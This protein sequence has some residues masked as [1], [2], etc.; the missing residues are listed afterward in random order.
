MMEF[1]LNFLKGLAI[2]I[3]AIA[4]GVSGGALAVIFGVYEKLNE[5]VATIFHGFRRKVIYLLPF[6]LGGGL[7][8]LAFSNIMKYLFA[9]HDV[10]MKYL[11]IGFMLGTLP[12]LIKEANTRGFKKRYIL[13]VIITFSI[14]VIFSMLENNAVNMGPGATPTIVDLIIYGALIGFGT[15]VP[16][17][18]A[19]FILMYLGAYE[20]LLE[21]IAS[22]NLFMLIPAGLGFVLSNLIFA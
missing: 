7:G 21:A 12:S 4:P 20:I 15:I 11:F 1:V 5:A 10:E 14:T 18:S 9:Y 22:V 17:I 2:G 3:G 16:G 19:S 13:P 6:A 8:V